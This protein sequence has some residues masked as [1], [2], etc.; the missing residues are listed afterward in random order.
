MRELRAEFELEPCA[1]VLAPLLDPGVQ[2][3][4]EHHVL[5]QAVERPVEA[6]GI[7]RLD[8]AHVPDIVAP[9]PDNIPR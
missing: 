8:D 1:H 6:I 5:V 2:L 9:R 4:D 7:E 3:G